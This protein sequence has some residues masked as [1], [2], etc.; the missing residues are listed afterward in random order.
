[1]KPRIS[2]RRRLVVGLLFVVVRP[3]GRGCVVGHRV[4]F[5]SVLGACLVV[6]MVCKE[7]EMVLR[8]QEM[9][10]EARVFGDL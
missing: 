5:H 9:V 8:E 4:V 7:P 2:M 6:E 10:L 3:D 1:M